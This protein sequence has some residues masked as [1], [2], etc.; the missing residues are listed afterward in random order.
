MSPAA[1]NVLSSAL[2]LPETERLKIATALLDSADEPPGMKSPEEWEAEIARRSAEI[3]AGTV[4]LI[5]WEVV[6][7]RARQRLASRSNG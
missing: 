3:D 6:R 1:A 2:A 7:D 4:I 5:P